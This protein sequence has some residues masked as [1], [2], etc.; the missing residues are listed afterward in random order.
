MRS[1]HLVTRGDGC[2]TLFQGRYIAFSIEDEGY[3]WNLSRYIHLNPRNG[4]ND[5][6]SA[7]RRFVKDGLIDSVDPRIDRLR[8]WV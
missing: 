7:Y 5:P 4:G 6:T 2:R 3:Y 1:L 8:D